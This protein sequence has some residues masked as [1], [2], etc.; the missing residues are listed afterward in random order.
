VVSVS[1]RSAAV[2]ADSDATAGWQPLLFPLD[3]LAKVSNSRRTGR[4]R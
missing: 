1:A 3:V 4:A 2:L